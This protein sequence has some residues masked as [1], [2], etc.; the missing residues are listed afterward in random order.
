MMTEFKTLTGEEK[1]LLLKAP[2][3]VS[4]L[5]SCSPNQINETQKKDAIRLAHLKTFTA[6]PVLLP[7]YQEAEKHFAEQFDKTAAFYYPF[8]D[9]KRAALKE[10]ISRVGAIIAKLDDLLA[11]RL[12][13]SL[14]RYAAHVKRS[15][16]SVFQDFI[17][18]LPIKGLTD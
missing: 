14:E 11:Q 12:R 3:L 4:V 5:A 7:Y 10:E 16:H 1:A 9:A 2:V 6:D 8:D 17:F 13:K 18:P 15:T